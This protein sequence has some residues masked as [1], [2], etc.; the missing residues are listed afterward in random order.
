MP[1]E[2][3]RQQFQEM[4]ADELRQQIL[5][6]RTRRRTPNEVKAKTAKK[7]IDIDLSKLSPD[8]LREVIALLEDGNES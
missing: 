2:N 8:E 1:F 7:K 6:M 5:D 4:T 3:L